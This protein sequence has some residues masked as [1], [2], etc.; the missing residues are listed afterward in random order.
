[1]LIENGTTLITITGML[2]SVS[3]PS[4]L[5]VNLKI[6]TGI[7]YIT[8]LLKEVVFCIKINL[9]VGIFTDDIQN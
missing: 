1:M 4:Y 8:E 3:N 7:T 6:V 5:S 2:M 9:R